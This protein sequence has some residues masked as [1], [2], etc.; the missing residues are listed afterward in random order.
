MLDLRRAARDIFANA[1]S[2]MDAGLAVRRAVQLDG[3]HL[4]IVDTKFDLQTRPPTIYSIAIGKAA[5]AMA[6]ALEEIL[7]E[8]LTGGVISAPSTN[9]S[10]SHR[11]RVFAGGHPLPNEESLAAARAAFELLQRADDSSALI[12][13]LISGGGSAIM[14][15]PRDERI[16]LTDLREANRVLVSCGAS[17]AEINTVRRAFSSVK[18]GGLSTRAPRADQITLIISDTD[19]REE[20]NVASGP[21]LAPPPG[22]LDA[23]EIVARYK[24]TSHLPASVVNAITQY[25]TQRIESPHD[26]LRRHYVLLDNQRAIE[27]AAETARSMGFKVEI[28]GDIVEQPI[29]EGCTAL[30]SRLH[31]LRQRTENTSPVCLI[32]GGEFACPVRGPGVGGRNTETALRCAIEMDAR[33]MHLNT[34]SPHMIALSAGTDGIDGNSPAAGAVADDAT[35]SRAREMNLDAQSFLDASDSYTF[36]EKLGDVIVTGPTGTNVRDLRIMVA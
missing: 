2:H 15:W 5:G 27:H 36:F 16:T 28:A 33:G 18:G 17:I 9:T 23:V 31:D 10:L 7:G 22:T 4:T 24:L 19:P 11:W 21:T 8:R 25:P 32:S 26:A 20:A 14:E 35:L 3:A 30:V 34:E 6:L 13:F 29:G 12:I 1:L